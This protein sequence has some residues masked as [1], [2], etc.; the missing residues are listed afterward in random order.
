ME[1]YF[2]LV[3]RDQ[4]FVLPTTPLAILKVVGRL[5]ESLIVDDAD[6]GD[7][8]IEYFFFVWARVVEEGKE[9]NHWHCTLND[10]H[11]VAS[12]ISFM[13]KFKS[14]DL[15]SRYKTQL[16]SEIMRGM[17]VP[18]ILITNATY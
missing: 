1:H 9:T 8:T 12:S 11:I 10:V 16:D 15:L 5:S 2:E 17:G 7:P 14:D 18:K 6:I 4:A 13:P 3:R